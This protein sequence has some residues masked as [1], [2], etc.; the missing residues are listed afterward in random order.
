MIALRDFEPATRMVLTTIVK[1]PIG[2]NPS[3][4]LSAQPIDM[5]R[6]RF[7]ICSPKRAKSG[8]RSVKR[9]LEKL[10]PGNT[11]LEVSVGEDEELVELAVIAMLTPKS[12]V[13]LQTE[14]CES[15][16]SSRCSIR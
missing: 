10:S 12:R 14:E 6:N 1:R 8:A 13:S 5:L 11:L 2:P 9:L 7:V 15:D 3:S 16:C 4:K